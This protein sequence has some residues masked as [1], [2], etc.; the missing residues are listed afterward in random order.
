MHLFL[1]RDELLEC[2]GDCSTETGGSVS[3][4]LH[5]CDL[6]AQNFVSSI[7]GCALLACRILL[8]HG[9]L[10]VFHIVDAFVQKFAFLLFE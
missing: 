2:S 4:F 3:T 1:I 8:G 5:E 10:F 7:N 9:C 6:L